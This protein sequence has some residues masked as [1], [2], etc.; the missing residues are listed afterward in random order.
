MRLLQAE[1]EDFRNLRRVQLEL[2]PHFTALVGQNGQG[3]TNTLEALYLLG[4]LRPLRNVN[5]KALFREGTQQSRLKAKVS[6]R[7]SGLVHQLEM[8]LQGTSRTLL[9]DEKRSAATSFLGTLVAVAFT[10]DDL[11]LGKG[12]PEGRRRFLDRALLNAKP[13]Y[14]ERALRYSKALKERN[15]ALV[16]QADDAVI[17]AFEGVLVEEGAAIMVAR[18]RYVAELSPRVEACFERI[19][20]PAPA[21]ALRYDCRL[22]L[23][24]ESEARTRELYATVLERKRPH[25][26]R[27]KS[28]SVGPHLDDLELMLDGVAA[29]ERASQGQHR[30]MALALKLAEL[31]DLAERLGEPPI[32]LLDDMS[33]ELDAQRSRQLFE[34]VGRLDGQVILTATEAPRL[35]GDE[36]VVFYD[37]HQGQLTRRESG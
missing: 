26:R 23:D 37:V 29:K 15:R 34:A 6:H 12:G 4:A 5:R 36:A 24:L 1:V 31:E 2:S 32:L 19:A 13:S 27:R 3:K 11:S 10:P 17:A 20:A 35:L 7:H 14:L 30:A 9:K 28:T 18:G 33:S 22:E 8:V 25:D 21:L 16:E